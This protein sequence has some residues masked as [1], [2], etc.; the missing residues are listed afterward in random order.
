VCAD[1]RTPS[2]PMALRCSSVPRTA[3]AETF[4]RR[5]TSPTMHRP[6]NI[7]AQVEVSGT[8]PATGSKPDTWSDTPCVSK[9]AA[10]LSCKVRA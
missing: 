4:R 2:Y 8:G 10:V 7:I 9:A 6:A 1:P 5:I 3:A